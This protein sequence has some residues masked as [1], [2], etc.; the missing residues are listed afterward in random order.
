M[1]EK[2]GGE[3]IVGTEQR[4]IRIKE[5]GKLLLHGNRAGISRWDACTATPKEE[6]MS[7]FLES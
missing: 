2:E 3:E 4:C 7:K 5:Q 1:D 6:W